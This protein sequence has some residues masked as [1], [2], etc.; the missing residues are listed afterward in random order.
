MCAVF[1]FEGDLEQ[2]KR[3]QS[4]LAGQE[5]KAGK[6]VCT[7]QLFHSLKEFKFSNNR[8]GV[9]FRIPDLGPS[10]ISGS[11]KSMQV[12]SPFLE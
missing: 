2:K 1:Q 12:A 10:L 11:I 9:V 8:C 6:L 5:P 4:F 3:A 7:E